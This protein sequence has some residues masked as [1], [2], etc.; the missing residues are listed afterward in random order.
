VSGSFVSPQLRQR[1]RGL[2]EPIALGLGRLGLS[3]NALTLIGFGIAIIAAI[4]AAQQRWLIA[5]LLVLGGGVFD[6]FDGAL[7]RATG[8][9]SKRGAFL[10]S[11]FDRAGE[12][13]VYVGIAYGSIQGRSPQDAILAASAMGAA[14]LVSYSRAKAESLGFSSG[15]GIANVGFAPREVRIV[16]LAFGLV[17]APMTVG[18]M[19]SPAGLSG[20]LGLITILATVTTIQRIIHVT[21]QAANKEQQ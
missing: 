17:L 11:V 12:A 20:P 3:P 18:G 10:D 4:A 21:R 1:V 5:G 19:A 15:S 16:I 8:Q 2:A 6:L 14:F 9:A 7:A 13:I